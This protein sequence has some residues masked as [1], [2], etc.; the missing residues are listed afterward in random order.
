[1]FFFRPFLTMVWSCWLDFPSHFGWVRSAAVPNNREVPK[2]RSNL[3]KATIF[4]WKT[5]PPPCPLHPLP[6]NM[7]R[8]LPPYGQTCAK[9]KFFFSRIFFSPLHRKIHPPRRFQHQWSVF[10]W[11]LVIFRQTFFCPFL[12]YFLLI[13]GFMGL[14]KFKSSSKFRRE[15]RGKRL[16]A[17]QVKKKKS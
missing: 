17:K 14:M 4:E 5:P 13:F 1:M 12:L 15:V 2:T 7:G 11:V 3:E 8:R 6:T 10:G 16:S 9:E